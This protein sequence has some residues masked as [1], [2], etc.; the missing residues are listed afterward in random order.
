MKRAFLVKSWAIFHC[1][2]GSYKA[3]YIINEY[4]AVCDETTKTPWKYYKLLYICVCLR[5]VRFA[6]ALDFLYG[7]NNNDLSVPVLPLLQCDWWKRKLGVEERRGIS[8]LSSQ[9]PLLRMKMILQPPAC[10]STLWFLTHTW[11]LWVYI[12]IITAHSSHR[13]GHYIQ[14]F[15]TEVQEISDSELSKWKIKI[16]F[17]LF[18]SVWA[19]VDKAR[20]VAGLIRVQDLLS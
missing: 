14:A 15:I 19:S 1:A 20:W 6:L 4:T 13:L 9:R 11:P 7:Y 18:R 5:G 10:L 16:P 3:L 17:S 2:C 12:I 8:K